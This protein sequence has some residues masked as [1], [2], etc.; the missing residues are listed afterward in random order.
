M[1]YGLAA[2]LA[3][4]IV[5]G[6][7]GVFASQPLGGPSLAEPGKW[8]VSGGYFYSKDKWDSNTVDGDFKIET[9]TYYAQFSYGLAPGWDMYLRAGAADVDGNGELDM[10][11]DAKFFGGI[12]LHGRFYENKKWNLSLGPVANFSYYSD[13]KDSTNGLVD[14]GQGRVSARGSL[15]MRDHY[16]FDVGFGFRYAPASW[17]SFYGG[18]F[19]HYETANLKLDLT[20][21]NKAFSDDANVHP[22]KSFGTRL[23]V[24]LPFSPNVGLQLEGQFR[25]YF[26]GG[27]QIF[28]MF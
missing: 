12:G 23:G 15:E 18:P 8:A 27:G 10:K 13:W 1:K 11:D 3:L 14:L 21:N 22:K 2:I 28:F 7:T 24:T 19:Y 25:D 6:G 16:S 5:V 26:S 20:A 9:N 4:V 17:I